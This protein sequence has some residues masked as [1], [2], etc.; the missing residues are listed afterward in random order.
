MTIRKPEDLVQRNAKEAKFYRA[1]RGVD[2]EAIQ[3]ITPSVVKFLANE[4]S[5]LGDIF[6]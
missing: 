2:E 3:V 6:L 1:I 5:L 4:I